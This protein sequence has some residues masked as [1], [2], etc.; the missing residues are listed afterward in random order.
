MISD[1]IKEFST[2]ES[3]QDWWNNGVHEMS[4]STYIAF[5]SNAIIYNVWVLYD[6]E[7]DRPTFTD[8]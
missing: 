4:L 8:C 1:E 5:Y 3:M 7:N 2:A 6:Q